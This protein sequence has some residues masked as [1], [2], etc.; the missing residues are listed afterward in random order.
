MDSH[1]HQTLPII[2]DIEAS[3]FGK[4][5]YPIEIGL[6]LPDRRTHCTLIKPQPDWTHWTQEGESLHHLSHDKLIRYGKPVDEVTE[7]LNHLLSGCTV[8]SDGWGN[9]M[10]W[11]GLLYDVAGTYPSFRIETL[12]NIVSEEQ[13]AIWHQTKNKLQ[14]EQQF[15]RH[16]ASNDALIIQMTYQLTQQM[17]NER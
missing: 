8:Y 17:V 14:Q 7:E 2:I 12:L 15:I 3:G 4:G 11:L 10:S 9:D 5:S 1:T 13:K 16:R 6:A